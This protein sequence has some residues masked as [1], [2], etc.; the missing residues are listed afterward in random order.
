[1][2]LLL[3]FAIQIRLQHPLLNSSIDLQPEPPLSETEM[4]LQIPNFTDDPEL[5]SKWPAGFYSVSL[6]TQ[7]TGVPTVVSNCVSMP[8]SP[9]IKSI[10]PV[11]APAGNIVFTIECLPQ[12]RD[13]QKV[14]LLFGDQIIS[15]D[16]INTPAEPTARTSITFT[17]NNAVSKVTPYILRLRVDGADSIPI[18]FSGDTPEFD[19]NQKVTVT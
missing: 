18:D 1:M 13:G 17:V 9:S 19:D 5:G 11:S 7:I 8:L 14:S 12:I 2:K 3:L 10:D 16:V 6:V 15:P 4:E